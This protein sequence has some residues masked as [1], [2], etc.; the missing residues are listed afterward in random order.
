MI[1][2]AVLRKNSPTPDLITNHLK[3]KEIEI[4]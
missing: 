1:H 4:C 3:N 2:E